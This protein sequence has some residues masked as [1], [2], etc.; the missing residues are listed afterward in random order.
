[1]SAIERSDIVQSSGPPGRLE[2]R[3]DF[4]LAII[5]GKLREIFIK[6][7]TFV[8]KATCNWPGRGYGMCKMGWTEIFG[9][10]RT[11]RGGGN[12]FYINR[13]TPTPGESLMAAIPDGT[14]LHGV[15]ARAR[16]RSRRLSSISDIGF[17]RRRRVRGPSQTNVTYFYQ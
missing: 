14:A 3:L 4:L 13:Q 6:T 5:H 9:G 1:M 7:Y 15:G 12:G 16:G 10:H 11:G 2:K 17:A 8:D